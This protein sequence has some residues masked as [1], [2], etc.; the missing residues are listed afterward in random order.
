M[1]LAGGAIA[2]LFIS[3]PTGLFQ[4]SLNSHLYFLIVKGLLELKNFSF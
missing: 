4:F 1:L 3:G 2:M